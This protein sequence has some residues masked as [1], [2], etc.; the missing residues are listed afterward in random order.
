MAAWHLISMVFNWFVRFIALILRATFHTVRLRFFNS[1]THVWCSLLVLESSVIGTMRI[2]LSM[3]SLDHIYWKFSTLWFPLDI[4]LMA[5]C[6]SFILLLFTELF[7]C[8]FYFVWMELRFFLCYVLYCC[9]YY[10]L[11]LIACFICRDISNFGND[12]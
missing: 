8:V 3:S 12:A 5:V 4:D 10:N 2:S 1:K 7:H 6:F 9:C 11:I